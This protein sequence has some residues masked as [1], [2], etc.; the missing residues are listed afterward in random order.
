MNT[1]AW[2]HIGT[3]LFLGVVAYAIKSFMKIVDWID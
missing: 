3:I 2:W 1:I